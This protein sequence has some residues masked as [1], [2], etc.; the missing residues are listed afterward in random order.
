IGEYG[1]T[2]HSTYVS[3][4]PSRSRTSLP[5]CFTLY[6]PSTHPFFSMSCAHIRPLP[7]LPPLIPY[8]ALSFRTSTPPPIY[9]RIP[10]SPHIITRR[11]T[12]R[13]YLISLVPT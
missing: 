3:L 2:Y 7:T 8:S 9:A 5:T 1:F 10:I 11:T 12:Y 4:T 6:I 13:A